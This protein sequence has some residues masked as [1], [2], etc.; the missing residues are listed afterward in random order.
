M[1][2]VDYMNA[3]MKKADQIQDAVARYQH[4]KGMLDAINMEGATIV[5]YLAKPG[6]EAPDIC[7]SIS[8]DK[9]KA[10]AKEIIKEYEDDIR[11]AYADVNV[12]LGATE[13]KAA[14]LP[15]KKTEE[16]KITVDNS[17]NVNVKV[18]KSIINKDFEAA[19][20][21]MIAEGKE[22]EK[23]APV[24]QQTGRYLSKDVISDSELKRLY[25][26]EGKTTV[27]IAK[28][29]GIN[30]AS[31]YKRLEEMKKV[32]HGNAKECARPERREKK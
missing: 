12:I 7:L 31:L 3:A 21:K 14:V 11:S 22:K 18:K 32:L 25:F 16:K 9:K 20:D 28:M 13:E 5:V 8:D 26:K 19:V 17:D 2:T 24:Q 23:V 30:P 1:E 10:L 27:D 4:A 6:S 29:Y 15:K